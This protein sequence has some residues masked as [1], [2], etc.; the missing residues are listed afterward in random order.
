MI[1]TIF[2]LILLYYLIKYIISHL[3]MLKTD[4]YHED[5]VN[6]WMFTYDFKE[7]KKDS[8][9]D[10]DSKEILD[11]RSKK[12]KLILFLYV[13]VILAFFFVNSLVAQILLLM[14]N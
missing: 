11:A 14:L 1:K 4:N 5:E 6:Y 9:F 10:K 3:R 7:K 13:S 2:I 8:I 12:N